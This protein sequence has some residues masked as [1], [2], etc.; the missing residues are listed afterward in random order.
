MAT[1]AAAAAATVPTIPPPAATPPN[2]KEAVS[3][4]ETASF[5]I[6]YNLNDYFNNPT[7]FIQP[8]ILSNVS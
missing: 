5:S 4:N 6:L 3:N 2:K 7:F 1:P 8:N